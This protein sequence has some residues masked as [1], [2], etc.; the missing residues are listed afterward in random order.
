MYEEKSTPER[1]R[2]KSVPERNREKSGLNDFLKELIEYIWEN[3]NCE[4]IRVGISHIEQEKDKYSP[5]MPLK[6]AYQGLNFKWKT[7]T[8]G[9]DGKRILILGLSRPNTIIFNNPR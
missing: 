5:Y 7:L 1:N 3:V 2:E 4:E 8:N 9:E 6:S